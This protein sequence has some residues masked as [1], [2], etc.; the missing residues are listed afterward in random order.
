VAPPRG[1]RKKVQRRASAPEAIFLQLFGAKAQ[2]SRLL[3]G[4]H[5]D[6]IYYFS[7]GT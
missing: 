2:T 6:L 4:D 5:D 7:K 1:L 3:F